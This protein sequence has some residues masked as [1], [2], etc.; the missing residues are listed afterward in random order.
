MK[1]R[2]ESGN[3]IELG[4][5]G[6]IASP[7]RKRGKPE[8]DEKREKERERESGVRGWRKGEPGKGTKRWRQKGRMTRRKR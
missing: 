1:K 8:R 2:T 6:E 5:E 3:E 4:S 7:E